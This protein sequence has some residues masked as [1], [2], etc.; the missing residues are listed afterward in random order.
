M[1]AESRIEELN[2]IRKMFMDNLEQSL[3]RYDQDP[4]NTTSAVH[5]S[6][7]ETQSKSEVWKKERCIRITASR[8]KEFLSN[9]KVW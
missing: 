2:Q 5:V 8:F 7:S 9:P 3:N 1:E 4:L 6:N